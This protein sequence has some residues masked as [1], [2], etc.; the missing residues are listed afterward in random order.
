MSLW[1][2]WTKIYLTIILPIVYSKVHHEWNTPAIIT[3]KECTKSV[4]KTEAEDIMACM[5][6]SAHPCTDFYE[7]VCGNWPKKYVDVNKQYRNLPWRIESVLGYKAFW[8]I[9]RRLEEPVTLFDDEYQKK[10]KNLY[11]VCMNL[12]WMPKL[13]ATD[14]RTYVARAGPWPMFPLESSSESGLFGISTKSSPID[15]K[16]PTLEIRKSYSPYG[17]FTRYTL[18]TSKEMYG[19]I[20]FLKIIAND[21]KP[22]N[23]IAISTKDFHKSFEDVLDFR[24]KL[25]NIIKISDKETEQP[26]TIDYLNHWYNQK[27]ASRSKNAEIPWLT[28]IQALY[29]NDRNIKI[30]DKTVVLVA[31]ATYFERL[32]TL[33][34]KTSTETIVNHI[35]LYFIERH[36]HLTKEQ[37]DLNFSWRSYILSEP[38]LKSRVFAE[39]WYMC[40]EKN[41][42]QNTL[43]KIYI[44]EHSSRTVVKGIKGLLND[45]QEMMG[46]QINDSAWLDDES[47]VATNYKISQMKYILGYPPWYDKHSKKKKY[48]HTELY[49]QHPEAKYVV[50]EN[51]LIITS[52]YM[53]TPVYDISL[54]FNLNYGSMGAIIAH[55]MYHSVDSKG[56]WFDV[57]G[58]KTK[59]WPTSMIDTYRQKKRCFIR[60]YN[61]YKIK[62][63]E[64]YPDAPKKYAFETVE[65]DMC[66][67]MGLKAAYEAY[68]LKLLKENHICFTLPHLSRYTCDEL[69]FISFARSFCFGTITPRQLIYSV[70]YD[71]HNTPRVRVNGAVSNMKEFSTAFR[72]SVNAPLNPKKRCDLWE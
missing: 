59:W 70:R 5:N 71:E 34:A 3:Y 12:P 67:T 36:L 44:E 51:R 62:E 16:T 47:K 69:F 9:R 17:L 27:E 28:V 41:V 63:L 54:P 26:M 14:L 50:N 43:G 72:C 11:R 66:D 21:A 49:P 7:Y 58:K 53:Q 15:K 68:R 1:R 31:Y 64:E 2:P 38:N 29:K 40:I 23:G 25:Q 37:E 46:I 48:A 20:E 55:E 8:S 60:Q 19:Y 6:P 57:E 18:W 24:I 22:S 13:K 4:C 42:M 35:H 65:E 52:A 33:L 30:D 32:R 39:K 56:L 45:V 61:H 10:T